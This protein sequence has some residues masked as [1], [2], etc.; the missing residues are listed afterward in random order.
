ML[1]KLF[2]KPMPV[3]VDEASD[4]A[5]AVQLLSERHY[6][7]VLMDVHMPGL[8]GLSATRT[9]RDQERVRGARRT[10]IVALTADDADEDWHRSM[11]A[12]CD[13]HVTKPV[14]KARLREVLNEWLKLTAP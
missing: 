9:I 5:Q 3:R 2:M 10:P 4:G 13:A 8:D 11:D 7:L 6:D 14:S 12:G 1:L